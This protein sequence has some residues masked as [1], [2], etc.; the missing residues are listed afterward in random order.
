[1]SQEVSKKKQE[2]KYTQLE[3][4]LHL[5]EVSQTPPETREAVATALVFDTTS[6][7]WIQL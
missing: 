1:M 6:C 4:E 7:E 3:L 2:V 5:P